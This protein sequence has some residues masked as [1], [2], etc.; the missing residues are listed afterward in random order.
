[1]PAEPSRTGVVIGLAATAGAVLL[2][3]LASRNPVN[4]GDHAAEQT[5][6]CLAAAPGVEQLEVHGTSVLPF[7]ADVRVHLVLEPSATRAETRD[8]LRRVITC[9]DGAHSRWFDIEQVV[10]G[11]TTVFDVDAYGWADDDLLARR[12]AV[13]D[14]MGAGTLTISPGERPVDGAGSRRLV[15]LDV[16]LPAGTDPLPFVQAVRALASDDLAHGD[17]RAASDLG[18]VRTEAGSEQAVAALVAVEAA[19]VDVTDADLTATTAWLSV[20]AADVERAGA[21]ARAATPGTEVEVVAAA[22]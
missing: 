7:T 6:R 3:V 12:D 21:V 14:L 15:D 20:P 5:R 1:M 11:T 8:A 10:G 9:D 17:V 16:V 19:G 22:G 18:M 13:T 4:A 2:L